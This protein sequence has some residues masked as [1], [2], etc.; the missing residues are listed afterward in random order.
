MLITCSSSL[1]SLPELAWHSHQKIALYMV[2]LL[3]HKGS[4]MQATCLL[5][6]R[7]VYLISALLYF[8]PLPIHKGTLFPHK[9]P[10]LP[11][12]A[13]NLIE[14]FLHRMPALCRSQNLLDKT[15]IERCYI[16][17]CWLNK[18][19]K[20]FAQLDTLQS[21]VSHYFKSQNF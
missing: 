17:V 15:F 2:S 8:C 14:S 3:L 6:C 12:D 19:S 13:E 20:K 5:S 11:E 21:D 10:V 16:C 9:F 7:E 1:S 4:K 18:F